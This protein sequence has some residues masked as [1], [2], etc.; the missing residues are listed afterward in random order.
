[1]LIVVKKNR[2]VKLYISLAEDD[3]LTAKEL[4]KIVC[5][6]SERIIVYAEWKVM[7]GGEEEEPGATV[8]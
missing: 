2:W 8:V 4:N 5:K 3:A 1:M 7:I 6:K